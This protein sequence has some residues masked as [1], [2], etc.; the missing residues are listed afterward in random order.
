MRGGM[1]RGRS[2]HRHAC[3]AGSDLA[4]AADGR[5]APTRRGRTSWLGHRATNP[6]WQ[7]ERPCLAIRSRG[8]SPG[9]FELDLTDRLGAVH[10]FRGTYFDVHP[11]LSRLA[12]GAI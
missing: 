8:V 12:R 5:D 3:H 7:F 1:S 2:G 4:R 10:H 11:W 9:G 6:E